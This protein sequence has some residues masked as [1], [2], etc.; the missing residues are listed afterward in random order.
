MEQGLYAQVVMIRQKDLDI[1]K[2]RKIQFHPAAPVI[3]YHQKSS[4]SCCLSSLASAFYYIGDNRAVT[5]L[6]NHIEE[7][8]KLQTEK[9]RNIIYFDNAIIT[10]IRKIKGGKN[11]RYN[12]K[13]CQK[14]NAFDVLENII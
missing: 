13:V 3:K 10:N 4:N 7:S 1:K 9:F 5:A 12:L 14:N 11:L 2:K 8:L 6:V